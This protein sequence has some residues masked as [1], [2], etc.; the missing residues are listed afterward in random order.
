MRPKTLRLNM[1]QWQGGAEP[2]YRFGAE[3]LRWL[4]PAH[5]GPEE[6]VAVPA[7]A[8]Q[9]LEIE[10]GIK[11]RT[12][13]LSQARAARAAIERHQPDRIVTLGGDCLIDLA[14]MAYLNRRYAGKL[15][16]LWVDAHPDIMSAAEFSHAHA[17]PQECTGEPADHEPVVLL[18]LLGAACGRAHREPEQRGRGQR[19]RP[20]GCSEEFALGRKCGVHDFAA[21]G[22]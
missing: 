15:G 18:A 9:A 7:A 2:A 14:P 19:D 4:A 1:P 5:D 12:A 20:R 22:P 13:L 21:S 3:L 8:E 16:V 10:Q 11:A 17:A 6:T